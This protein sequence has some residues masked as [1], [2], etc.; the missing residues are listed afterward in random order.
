VPVPI[1]GT[2]LTT[3]DRALRIVSVGDEFDAD[4]AI[5]LAHQDAFDEDG[6]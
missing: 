5:V 4:D 6:A 1:A 3:G 2:N